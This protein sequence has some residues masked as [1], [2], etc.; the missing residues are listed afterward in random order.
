MKPNKPTRLFEGLRSSSWVL[1]GVWTACI[2]GSWLWNLHQS[3]HRSLELARLT[4]QVTF[5]NDVLYRRWAARQGGVYVRVTADTPPNPHLQVTNR[6]VTTTSGLALTLVNPAYMARQVN[7]LAAPTAGSRGHLTSLKPIRPENMPDPWE[8]EALRSFERGVSEVSSLESMAHGQY[9]RFMRPF[10]TEQSCLECHASQ[11][12]RLGDVRGGISVSVPMAP[13]QAVEAP[14][15]NQLAGAHA[16]LWLIGL[17]G[18]GLFQ[19][20]LG[21]QMA[22]RERASTDLEREVAERRLAEDRLREANERYELVLA[23]AEAGLW[24]WDVRK[25]K[26]IFSPRWKTMR[27]LG[28]DE[29]GDAEEEWSEGI[30]PEDAP[31]V[32]AAVQAHF[33][34]RTPFFAEEYRVRRRDGSW[35]W[36]IDRGLVRRDPEGR[37]VRMAGSEI[38]ITD[39]K[40]AEMALAEQREELQLILDTSPALIFYKDRENR[41]LRVN[42][43]VAD[44]MG[45]PKEQLEGWSLNELY[46]REQ[47]DAYWKDDREVMASDCAKL[48]IIEPMSTPQGERWFQTVKVPC[49]DAQGSVIGIIGF[50]LDITERER[51]I[52]ALR[53]SEDRLRFALEVSQT[54]AW[55]LDLKN[56]TAFRS[57]EHDRIFG[58]ADLLPEWTYEMFLEHVLPEDRAAV[59]A[60]FREATESHGDWSF[61]CRIRRKDGAVRWIWAAGRYREDATQGQP[62]MGGIVQDITERKEGEERLRQSAAALQAANASLLESRQAALN[63]MD[64]AVAARQDAERV[65]AKLRQEVAVREQAEGELRR[66]NRDLRVL[67]NSGQALMRAQEEGQFLD[68]ICQIIVRDC[69]YTKVWVGLEEA[70]EA[71]TVRPVAS[72][73]FEAGSLESLQFTWADTKRDQSPTGTVI[74]T[75]K[76]V[77]CQNLLAETQRAPWQDE[78]SRRGSAS[79]VVLPLLEEGQAIGAIHIYAAQPDQFSSDELKLLTELTDD[80]S[81]GITSIR[82]R[83]AH[84]EAEAALQRSERLYRAIGESIE[85]GIWVCEPDGR[86]TYASE[87]FLKLVGLTQEECSNFGWGSVLHP[88]DADRTIAAWKQCVQAGGK[89]DIE[90]R[91]RGVDGHYHAVLARGVPV[92]NKRGDIICWAGIN[93]DISRLKQAEEA[94]RGSHARL[95]ILAETASELLKTDSPQSVVERLCHKVLAFLDCQV[96]FNFIADESTRRLRLNACAGVSPDE[97]AQ[98]QWLDYGVAVC[99]CAARDGCRVIAE[100]IPA[101]SDPRTELVKRLGVQAYACHPLMAQGKVLGTLSFGTRHRTRFTE[102]EI[103]LMKA[104]ADQVAIAMQRKQAEEELRQINA[105]LEQRVADRTAQL[106]AVARYARSLIEASLDPLVTI[107]PAGRITDVNEATELAT[108]VPRAR[109][110]GSSFSDYFTEPARADAGYQQVLAQGSVRDYPLTIRHASGRTTDVLYHATVYRNEG[111][112]VQGVFAAARDITERK[113]AEMERQNLRDE[114]ARVS[115]ITTAGQLAASLAHELNQPLGA[116]ACNIQAIENLLAQPTPDHSEVREAL[117]DIDTSSQRAGA[118]IHQLRSLYRKTGRAQTALQ[119]NDLLRNTT[120]LLHSELVLRQVALE[121]DLDPQLPPVCA[122]GV[123]LQQ[124]ALNLLTNAVEA[125]TAS[126]EGRR[127]LHL[128]TRRDEPG[129][130]RVSLRDSGPGLT[131]EQARRVFEPFY[132]TKPNGMGMGLAICHSIIEAHHGRLWAENNPDGGATFHL[133]LPVYSHPEP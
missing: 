29:V 57:L 44:I 39:R 117:K 11:G 50:A 85:Y 36:I 100:N 101:T 45:R 94:L 40:K 114:L 35:M 7:A 72:A 131:P 14:M 2:A 130:I 120:E 18:V 128:R 23:G 97:T 129:T 74:R 108:G 4:A 13:L 93:L 80:V 102:E 76:M 124:V 27:G 66:L 38:E 32:K 98:L 106:E 89:W 90:H 104:V 81:R 49:H 55:D 73:G 48:D 63:L 67:S 107:S 17:A 126:A 109:L 122:N 46:P 113:A 132:T 52:S 12:Y 65:S 31:R 68:E 1:V 82:L 99:G 53:Q 60:K 56:H 8:A 20:T 19:R 86:N 43:A 77:V 42:R 28:E 37:V 5:E 79:A 10:V 6:D 64:D 123:E 71:K 47:A 16:G 69:G 24:D 30:H 83:R 25:H 3:A 87:S 95:D 78:A 121:L 33:E 91:F 133:S 54:G 111:G 125:M 92:R 34:G 118:I 15:A 41:F 116:I 88:D 51:A 110:I 26:V 59:D 75:G 84:T 70:D 61:A 127:H 9:F 105:Q 103:S 112:A 62:R 58:Y 119:L 21:K 96:F 22:A 115:R